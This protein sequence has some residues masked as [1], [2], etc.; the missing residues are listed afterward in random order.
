MSRIASLLSY[1]LDDDPF[2][3][4]PIEFIGEETRPAT[5]VD[6]AVDDGEDV[7][8]MQQEVLEVGLAIV[9]ADQVMAIGGIFGY[10][11]LYPFHD[12]AVQA[13]FLVP[14]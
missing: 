2:G 14:R 11:S 6:P 9:L 8:V 1:D 12:V 13:R 3:A 10:K 7:L 4:L 5:R